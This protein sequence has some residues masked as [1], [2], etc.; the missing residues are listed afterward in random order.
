MFY[1]E[2]FDYKKLIYNNLISELN[3]ELY[4]YC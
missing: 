2:Y 1:F 3:E 4:K